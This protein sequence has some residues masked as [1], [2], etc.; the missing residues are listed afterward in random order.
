MAGKFARSSLSNSKTFF[1]LETIMH[2]TIETPEDWFTIEYEGLSSQ[3]GESSGV[4]PSCDGDITEGE[5]N[6]FGICIKC[7]TVEY[8]Q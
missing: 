5:W 2:T 7:A 4:C 3:A 8:T 1:Y 6:R